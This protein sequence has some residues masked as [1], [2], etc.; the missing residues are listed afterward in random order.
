VHKND[1][2]KISRE[3][4]IFKKLDVYLSIILKFISE[5]LGVRVWVGFSCIR[6]VVD[7]GTFL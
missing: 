4:N 2:R 3:E 6:I 7:A 1:N 5:L